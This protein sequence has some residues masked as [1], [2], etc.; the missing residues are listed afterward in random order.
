MDGFW[1]MDSAPFL[2]DV[3]SLSLG[4]Q[5]WYVPVR[6]VE[7][8]TYDPLR[9]KSAAQHRSSPAMYPDGA[10]RVRHHRKD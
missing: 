3:W 2:A 10:C 4:L 6:P 1:V 9:P 5:T 7:W 8:V